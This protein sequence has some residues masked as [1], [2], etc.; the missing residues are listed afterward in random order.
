MFGKKLTFF[1][2]REELPDRDKE[3][4]VNKERSSTHQKNLV[5]LNYEEGKLL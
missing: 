1:L 3:D 5:N 4:E 2:I